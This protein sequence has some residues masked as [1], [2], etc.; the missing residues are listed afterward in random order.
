MHDKRL[1]INAPTKQ[2]VLL[3]VKNAENKKEN[4]N[5][6]IR[7]MII[8]KNMIP[9]SEYAYKDVPKQMII[10]SAIIEN[11]NICMAK[12]EKR[13]AS[14]RNPVHIFEHKIMHMTCSAG[15]ER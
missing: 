11:T 13:Y 1:H 9:L 3:S 14:V 4:P 15:H 12:N 7:K 10:I 2:A 5:V 8:C 6:P